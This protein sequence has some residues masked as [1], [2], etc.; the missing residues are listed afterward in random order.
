MEL[1]R[2]QFRI[3]ASMAANKED[4]ENKKPVEC[5][6]QELYPV[7]ESMDELTDAGYVNNC[8]IT[9]KGLAALEPYKVK[10]AIFLAAGFGLRL[11]PI[12]LNTP[13]PLVR[14]NGQRIID[15]LIDACL[16]AGVEEI[17]IVRGYLG[18]L[19]DQ[20]LYK[21]P[22]IKFVDNLLFNEANN[23]SSALAVK[24]L[25]SN[26]Y[27]LESDF[28]INN[29]AIIKPYHYTSNFLAI[30]KERTDDWC[31]RVTDRVIKEQMVGGQGDDIWQMVGISYWNKED[32]LKLSQDLQSV[33]D[34][35]EG[36]QRYWDQVPLVCYKDHYRVEIEECHEGDIIEI[37]TFD[38]LKVIDRSYEIKQ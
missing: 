28:L 31:F 23:I 34:S 21:Y 33:F 13:K 22:M 27:V 6:N 10:R 2:K 24:D 9:E 11:A 15:G 38:E 8:S 14:V 19:F 29:K 25:L 5:I 7:G 35:Q 37:D 20:L 17:M 4:F 18:G 36:K 1:N 30:K 3:L 16:E 12:T 26:A 32:G